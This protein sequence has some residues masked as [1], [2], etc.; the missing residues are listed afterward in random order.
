MKS[1]IILGAALAVVTLCSTQISSAQSFE[2]KMTMKI[3]YEE[4]P[5]E[6]ESYVGALPK[7]SV[8]FV[9]GKKNRT[10]QITMMGTQ[11]TIV[12]QETSAGII[13]MDM[14]GQK[15]A[16]KM[17]SQTNELNDSL[18]TPTITYK[19]ETK[20][21]A[22]YNCKKAEIKYTGEEDPMTIWYTEEIMSEGFNKFNSLKGL[23]MQ[24]T[25]TANGMVMTMTVTRVSKETVSD[26]KFVIPEG[27]TLKTKEELMK[28]A[29]GG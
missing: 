7:E 13:L 1:K 15:I 9:K 23:P 19:D 28:M 18:G 10:E 27:Y 26:D 11:I 2:G 12:D 29:T 25:V 4:V 21:I 16:M 3:E 22:G 5:E 8:M 14:M 20:E 6:M 24:Y 17:D